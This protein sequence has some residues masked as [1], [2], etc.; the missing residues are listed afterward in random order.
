MA[1]TAADGPGERNGGRRAT[2]RQYVQAWDHAVG[3]RRDRMAA[4]TAVTIVALIIV[5]SPRYL[6]YSS[7]LVRVERRDNAKAKKRRL[8]AMPIS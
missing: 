6:T 7:V 1:M 4:T 8:A 5:A 2:V 3:W